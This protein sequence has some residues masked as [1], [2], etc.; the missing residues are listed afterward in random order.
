MPRFR[1]QR[2]AQVHA[3]A[4]FD[5]QQHVRKLLVILVGVAAYGGYEGWP[6]YTA[7]LV[8]GALVIWNLIYFGVRPMQIATGGPLAYLF[9]ISIQNVVQA[10]AF[11]FAGVGLHHLIR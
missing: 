11:Y 3:P 9:R 10:T 1:G 6:L 8:G 7:F 4:I 2:G 5:R